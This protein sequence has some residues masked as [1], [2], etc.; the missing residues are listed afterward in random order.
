MSLLSTWFA[1]PSGSI[2][3]FCSECLLAFEAEEFGGIKPL[4]SVALWYHC[5]TLGRA[6]LKKRWLRK[7]QGMDGCPGHVEHSQKKSAENAES[8]KSRMNKQQRVS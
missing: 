1:F 7:G 3:Y 2:V 8:A 5:H 6:W 4:L